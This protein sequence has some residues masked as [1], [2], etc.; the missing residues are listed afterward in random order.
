[1]RKLI[2]FWVFMFSS[3]MMAQTYTITGRITDAEDKNEAL[4]GASVLYG[5]GR[6]TV[7]DVDGNYRISLPAGDYTITFSYVGYEKV[8][9][10]ISLNSD[11]TLDVQ[12]SSSVM[13][14]EVTVVADVAIARETPVAFSTLSPKTLEEN[15]A[16]QDIPM[17]LN[18]TPGVYA[19]QEGG[20]DGD[21]Q[22]TIRGF[23]SR[24]V[25]VLLDG[26]PVNDM[27]NGHVYWSNWFGLDAVTRSMQV[28]RGMGASKLALPSVG[29]TINIITKGMDSKKGGSFKQEL[30]SDGYLRSSFGYNTGM[31]K[32]GWAFSVAGSYKRGDGWVDQLWSEGVFYYA[33]VDKRLGKHTLSLSAYGAP[34]KHGQRVFK[35]PVAVYDSAYA[36]DLGIRLH[37]YDG[38]SSEDSIIVAQ[39]RKN[40]VGGIGQ[41][42]R[43]NQHWGYLARNKN[44]PD[45][46]SE[47]MNERVNFYHKPQITLKDIWNV[48]DKLY[49][50]N[51]AYLSIGRG[52]GTSDNSTLPPTGSD[53]LKDYQ[54]VYNK[55]IS[56]INT[57]YS[58]DENAATNFLKASMNEHF[59][60]GFLSTLSYDYSE[61]LSVSGGIDVRNY[62]GTHYA[63]VYDLLGADYAANTLTD[64]S[65]IDWNDEHP[66]SG[67]KLYEGDIFDYHTEGRVSW[68][69]GFGQLEY[70]TDK[71]ST[72][73]NLTAAKSYYSQT[74]FLYGLDPDITRKETQWALFWG[75]TAK[76]G[77]NYNI[78]ETMNVFMNVGY[79]SKAPEF[80]SVYDYDNR[81][82][83]N[84]Q[85]EIV[86]ALE[87]GYSYSTPVF[88]ANLNAYL[89]RW[90]N[91]PMSTSVPD[92]DEP[93]ES[94]SVNLN[95]MDALHK[96]VELDFIYRI[97]EGLDFQGL[98]SIGD[99]RWDTEG[100]SSLYDEDGSYIEDRYF[101]AKGVHVGNSA[102]T[103]FGGEFRWEPIEGLYVKPRATYFTRYYA[104]FEP[105]SLNPYYNPENFDEDGQPIDSWQ[106]PSY[107]LID[108]HTGYRWNVQ[109][110]ILDLRL[111]VLNL[112]NVT[113]IATAQDNDP[114]NGQSFNEHDA[115]SASVF[116]GMGRRFNMSISLKF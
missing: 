91:K 85:N 33:K 3:V 26:V 77:A 27:E 79:L 18:S 51:I 39:N 113:Y 116:M 68:F 28:Q 62:T 82:L 8:T 35:L 36:E 11:L 84:I 17:V 1:M 70:K 34:Q 97:I 96:G 89:T 72:F 101:N 50:S 16:A 102:Q 75:G 80:S 45:A 93:Q 14:K 104:Q 19:T 107:T 114:Y 46:K 87:L 2:F 21:A 29:G 23:D 20:G 7:A 54:S 92:P 98:M 106:I 60:Y 57:G 55:N 30:G 105:G 5:D 74:A 49:I 40:A 37:F 44:N 38:I 110:Y 42:V 112:M 47:P 12:L 64:Y 4:I 41:G 67:H 58:A 61:R 56:N 81:L 65:S 10:D 48:S 94:L 53:G 83:T 115:K 66:F 32:N 6:G 63:M 22:V 24:N 90:E 76:G 99:W 100:Y 88:S 78:N 111:N 95:G 59:W 43:Y 15:I 52:G 69:G 31:L 9:K 86:K 25:G 13:M 103:Q 108:L 73:L 71:L 109:D